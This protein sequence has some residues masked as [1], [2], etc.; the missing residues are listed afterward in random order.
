LNGR[1]RSPVGRAQP[2]RG[3]ACGSDEDPAGSS[4]CLTGRLP[5]Q[6][7]RLGRPDRAGRDGARPKSSSA[8]IVH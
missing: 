7:G 3:R 6:G 2:G 4:S 1:I 8:G 5:R